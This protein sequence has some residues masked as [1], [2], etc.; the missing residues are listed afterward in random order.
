MIRLAKAALLAGLMISAAPAA[1]AAPWQKIESAHFVIY[2][3]GDT[4]IARKYIKKLEGFEVATDTLLESFGD[5]TLPAPGKTIFYYLDDYTGFTTVVPQYHYA[6]RN[7]TR[8]IQDGDQYFTTAVSVNGSMSSDEVTTLSLFYLGY[9]SAKINRFFSYPLPAWVRSGL[10]NYLR[11]SDVTEDHAAMGMYYPALDTSP[12]SAKDLLP[13]ETVLN[14][15]VR[16]DA[17]ADKFSLQS[18]VMISYFMSTDARRTQFK[19]YLDRIAAGD[20]S[21]AAFRAAT[22][23]APDDFRQVYTDM[24]KQSIGHIVVPTHQPG[25]DTVTVTPGGTAD[26]PLIYAAL[27]ACPSPG[28]GKTLLG[29]AHH[30]YKVSPNGPLTANI[31]ARAEIGFGDPTAAI[32]LLKATLAQSPKD[33]ESQQLL[34]RAYLAL[35]ERGPT[36]QSTASYASALSEISKAY[37]LDPTSAPTLY[38]FARAQANRPNYPDDNTLNAID[39]AQEYSSDQYNVYQAELLLRRGDYDRALVLIEDELRSS[40]L[41]SDQKKVLNALRDGLAA[42]SRLRTCCRFSPATTRPTGWAPARSEAGKTKPR[43]P[44]FRGF[45]YS[46]SRTGLT[47]SNIR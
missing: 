1:M 6:I 15:R 9:S 42:K 37:T 29:L 43:K 13:F 25:D 11:T 2:S 19:A 30:A 31:L 17:D 35:A 32:P 40:V 4:K 18:W 39:L 36:D 28:Y 16:D 26:A 38:F 24:R 21:V 44:G 14:A 27:K 7:I 33:V 34:G 8:C 45:A 47:R 41:V 20:E 22:G 5:S 46:V 12:P 23:M 3:D 10:A